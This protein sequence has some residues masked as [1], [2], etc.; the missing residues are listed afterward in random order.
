MLH[1]ST[2]L[3]PLACQIVQRAETSPTHAVVLCH[4]FGAP[5]TDLVPVA[6]EMFERNPQWPDPLR[7]IFPA[8]P[9][10]L[11]ELGSPGARAWWRID[12]EILM[13]IQ[14]GD[15]ATAM[16][17]REECPDGLPQARRALMGLLEATRV[18]LSK[19]VL[20]GFSQGAMLTTDVALRLEEAP[21]ALAL[22]SGTTV[23]VAE[24]KKRAPVRRGL[25]VL[26]SHGREDPI[27]PYFAAEGLRDLLTEAGLCVE[28]IPFSGGHTLSGAALDRF[29][30]LVSNALEQP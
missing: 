25:R 15:M 9:L 5:G 3:G 17:L 28:F 11:P 14:Q 18:P 23:N 30:A 16:K 20:G 27:L 29:G 21:A 4:G 12:F 6:H 26:Q 10:E 1:R 19:T 22:F 8:A 13:R 24:W 2:T 7:F